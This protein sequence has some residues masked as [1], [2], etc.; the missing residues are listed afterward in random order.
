MQL[1]SDARMVCMGF[2]AQI[3]GLPSDKRRDIFSVA[4]GKNRGWT[5]MCF[6]VCKMGIII[7]L[8]LRG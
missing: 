5:R 8:A 2:G 7:V 1:F 3:R 6:F 4:E